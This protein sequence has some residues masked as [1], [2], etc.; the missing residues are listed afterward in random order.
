MSGERK[1]ER[2]DSASFD[3]FPDKSDAGGSP[4]HSLWRLEIGDWRCDSSG[5]GF[6]AL[7][8]VGNEFRVCTVVV[9]SQQWPVLCTLAI[10]HEP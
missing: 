4:S 3:L 5:L 7:G 2:K 6:T 10:H 1:K 8:L 9:D